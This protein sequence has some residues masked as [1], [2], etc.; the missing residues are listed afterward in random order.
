MVA[1]KYIWKATL[2]LVGLA[3]LFSAFTLIMTDTGSAERL[4]AA[5]RALEAWPLGVARRLADLEF[6]SGVIGIGSGL[7]LLHLGITFKVKD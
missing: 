4:L 1:L 2:I 6:Y 7:A 5:A 3:V